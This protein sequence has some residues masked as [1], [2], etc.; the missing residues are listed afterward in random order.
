ML[1]YSMAGLIG[2]ALGLLAGLTSYFLTV[3]A[4]Q[5]RL[6]ALAPQDTKEQRD[7]LEFKLGVMRR[8][9][10]TLDIVFFG[11]GGYWLGKTFGG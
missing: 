7:D 11:I 2:A 8:L 5:T 1:E 3:P 9:V 10:L 6:R 4:I